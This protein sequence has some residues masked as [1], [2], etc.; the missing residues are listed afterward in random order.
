MQ[1]V[2]RF[3]DTANS[4]PATVRNMHHC[5]DIATMRPGPK[6]SVCT[7]SPMVTFISDTPSRCSQ[8]IR[9]WFY[10]CQHFPLRLPYPISK[11]RRAFPYLSGSAMI[12]VAFFFKLIDGFFVNLV[13]SFTGRANALDETHTKTSA[14][15]A[16]RHHSSFFN[17][18]LSTSSRTCRWNFSGGSLSWFRILRYCRNDIPSIAAASWWFPYSFRRNS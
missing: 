8:Y 2:T 17:L 9:C 12:W 15:W 16:F 13:I 7:L 1:T 6:T 10:S 14:L 18:S 11:K 5:S 3:Q 4:F